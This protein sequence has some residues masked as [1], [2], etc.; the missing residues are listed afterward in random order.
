VDADSA[1]LSTYLDNKIPHTRP[2]AKTLRWDIL[3]N[4]QWH[5]NLIALSRIAKKKEKDRVNSLYA[6]PFTI[7]AKECDPC[8]VTDVYWNYIQVVA[9]FTAITLG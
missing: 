9:S 4:V 8:E 3:I 7:L 1:M 5:L 6:Q 2:A